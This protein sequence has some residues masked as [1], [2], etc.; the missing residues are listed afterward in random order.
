MRILA[1]HD[2]PDWSMDHHCQD[3][4]QALAGA[5]D[6]DI[7]SCGKKWERLDE[8]AASI[9]DD[10]DRIYVAGEFL[11]PCVFERLREP[12]R[13]K[14]L[15]GVHSYFLWDGERSVG[16]RTM[17]AA[18][19]NPTFLDAVRQFPH[20]AVICE[21]LRADLAEANPVL[22]HYGI[23]T[24]VFHPL[25]P[26]RTESARLQ[27]GWIGALLGHKNHHLFERIAAQVADVADAREIVLVPERYFQ[28]HDGVRSRAEMNR[29]YNALDLVVVT[30]DS[31]GGPLPPLEA[32]A[33]GVPAITPPIGCMP[34]FIRDGVDGHLVDSYDADDY[35][36][37]IRHLHANRDVLRQMREACL[38]KAFGAWRLE[39]KA[40]AWLELFQL[41]CGAS[42]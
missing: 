10:Y 15:L 30:A 36:R 32:A 31:E 42:A 6:L 25:T 3:L 22:A 5:C 34:E 39:E 41:P 18:D 26:A 11:G 20:A 7:W 40:K 16:R 38:E 23:N 13:R 8:V 24:A 4:K 29:F 19:A 28:P 9:P 21:S 17:R 12:Q 14:A 1:I 35:A 2:R 33:C 37:R 27:I